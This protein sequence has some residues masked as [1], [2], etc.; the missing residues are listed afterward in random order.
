[1]W[2]HPVTRHGY[3]AWS[4]S[5]TEKIERYYLSEVW[6]TESHHFPMFLERGNFAVGWCIHTHRESH[7]N[8]HYAINRSKMYF[9]TFLLCSYYYYIIS[10]H[11]KL[12]QS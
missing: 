12:N 11:L 1:M 4:G 9:R 2:C 7:S 8:T 10:D 6:V 3:P 5:Q